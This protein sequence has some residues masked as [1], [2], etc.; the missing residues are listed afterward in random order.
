MH[1]R[2]SVL[3]LGLFAVSAALQGAAACSNSAT[4]PNGQD[5]GPP[6]NPEASTGDGN[7]T[8]T[9]LGLGCCGPL[10]VMTVLGDSGTQVEPDWSCYA[11]G[12]EFLFHPVPMD[13]D[14][15]DGGDAA[16]D[17]GAAP[18]AGADTSPPIDATPPV[19]SSAADSSPPPDA[20]V[21]NDYILHLTDFVTGAPPVGANVDILWGP[22][23]VG[24][25]GGAKAA[26]DFSGTVDDAGLLFFKPPPSG[27]NLLTYEV[28]GAAQSDFIWLGAIIVAPPGQLNANSV[29]TSSRAEL[30]TSVLGSQSPDPNLALLVTA[31]EDCQYRDIMGG[32]FTVI[33]T[34]T[35]QPVATGTS[36][37]VARAFYLENNLPNTLC[38]YTTNNGRSVWSMIN[39]PVDTSGR[40]KIQYSGRMYA[41]QTAPVVIS[42]YPIESFAGA[43][44]VLRSGRINTSPPN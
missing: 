37:G 10:P 16:T 22:S 3:F 2:S 7:N 5:S 11:T 33:D 32:Q 29:A 21:A 23:R 38:T 44:T 27:T 20:A 25:G 24:D 28:T 12:A 19:D 1:R 40:Y 35:G 42:E 34:T 15:G 4:T 9:G 43:S 31:A 8:C 14:G 36:P 17:D 6:G 41:S 26:P 30:L 18:D 39:A 13:T